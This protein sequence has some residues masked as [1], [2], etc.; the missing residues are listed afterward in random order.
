MNGRSRS[1]VNGPFWANFAFWIAVMPVT[2]WARPSA[3]SCRL[4][5]WNLPTVSARFGAL[6]VGV[7]TPMSGQ[8]TVTEAEMFVGSGRMPPSAAP[9]VNVVLEIEPR[10]FGSGCRSAASLQCPGPR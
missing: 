8:L 3:R 10:E 5:F 4:R 2:T 7:P 6:I 9:S 1:P